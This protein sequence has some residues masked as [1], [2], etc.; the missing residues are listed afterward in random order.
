MH[1]SSSEETARS[2]SMSDWSMAIIFAYSRSSQEAP[3]NDREPRAHPTRGNCPARVHFQLRPGAPLDVGRG[4]DPRSLASLAR[5]ATHGHLRESLATEHRK[6]APP[7]RGVRPLDHEAASSEGM[8]RG[9]RGNP[10]TGIQG[11]GAKVRAD[12]GFVPPS[13]EALA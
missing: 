6:R 10:P 9:R 11:S 12:F 3:W 13:Q 5:R 8:V 1:T 2:Q 4:T 7:S